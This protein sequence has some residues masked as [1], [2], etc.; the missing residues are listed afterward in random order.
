METRPPSDPYL[1]AHIRERLAQDPRANVLDI[2]VEAQGRRLI[3]SGPVASEDRRKAITELVHELA[4]AHD[5]VDRMTLTGDLE[6]D[7]AEDVQ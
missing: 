5:T 2:Q 6:P 4:P 3:L 1:V 7:D